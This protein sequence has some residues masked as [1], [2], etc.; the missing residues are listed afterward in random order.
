[1]K[2]NIKSFLLS[3]NTVTLLI[4]I[5]A[6]VVIYFIYDNKVKQAVVLV[7]VPIAKVT[8]NT[9][10]QITSDVIYYVKMPRNVVNDFE[11]IELNANNIIGKLV[12]YRSTIEKNSFFF[13]E[14]LTTKE[15]INDP[16]IANIPDGDTVFTLPVNLATTLGNSIYPGNY[17]DLYL[18]GTYDDGKVLYGKFVESIQVLDVKDSNGQH[19]F[20]S[21]TENRIPSNL[22]FAVPDELHQLLEKTKLYST[23]VTI[24]PVL[25][26]K[27][28]VGGETKI[29][30]TFLESWILSKTENINDSKVNNETSE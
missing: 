27:S 2:G 22:L 8:I 10:E 28:Y 1:M 20:E 16:S 21:T 17:I 19:V 5:I 4:T 3:K 25:R 23:N 18:A 29:A 6:I 9:R 15:E 30:S 7:N 24:V 13:S 12:N 14:Q 26:N 11:N